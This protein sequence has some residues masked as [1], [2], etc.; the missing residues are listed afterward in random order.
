MVEKS[1]VSR[2]EAKTR[3]LESKLE[4]ER[5]Q[6]KRLEVGGSERR[7]GGRI[8]GGP[9]HGRGQGG[10][11]GRAAPPD[12]PLY[13]CEIGTLLWK[14]AVPLKFF[15][16]S[17]SPRQRSGSPRVGA[18]VDG[19]RRR[20]PHVSG[21]VRPRLNVTKARFRCQLPVFSMCRFFLILCWSERRD[22]RERRGTNGFSRSFPQCS[23]GEG[24]PPPVPFPLICGRVGNVRSPPRRRFIDWKAAPGA[25]NT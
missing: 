10:V 12:A 8:P 11:R 6:V 1:L 15:T 7:G 25:P 2:Q 24:P 23:A 17:G 19:R 21:G 4:F 16:C 13:S 5:T 18:P 3:E 20:L 22:H 14:T 9:D